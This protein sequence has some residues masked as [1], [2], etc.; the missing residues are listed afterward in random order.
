[1]VTSKQLPGD[2]ASAKPKRRSMGGA[3]IFFVLFI[4]LAGALGIAGLGILAPTRLA[5]IQE[6]ALGLLHGGIAAVDEQTYVDGCVPVEGYDGLRAIAR[7]H[8]TVIFNDGTS[9]QV[10]FSGKPELTNACP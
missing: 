8:R 3:S 7:T 1:M 2:S 9:L 4:L 5:T 10:I 6:Q